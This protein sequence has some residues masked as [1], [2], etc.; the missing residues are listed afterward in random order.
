ML[1]IRVIDEVTGWSE[2]LSLPENERALLNLQ[3][4]RYLSVGVPEEFSRW[5]TQVIGAVVPDQVDYELRAPSPAQVNFALAIARSLAIALPPGVLR[6]R[7]EMHVFLSAHKEAFN[8]R[9]PP[10]AGEN[11]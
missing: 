8:K 3:L 11:P 7:G 1:R 6:F 5:L 10:A 4:E 9:R 2:D